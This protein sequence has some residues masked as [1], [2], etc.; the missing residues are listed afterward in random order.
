MSKLISNRIEKKEAMRQ[1][2]W[3][4]PQVYNVVQI[5]TKSWHEDLKCT[6]EIH[7]DSENVPQISLARPSVHL[8]ARPIINYIIWLFRI[9]MSWA[10]WHWK[11]AALPGSWQRPW[12]TVWVGAGADRRRSPE[13]EHRVG[14]ACWP[15]PGSPA[16]AARQSPAIPEY[17][18]NRAVKSGPGLLLGQSAYCSRTPGCC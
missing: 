10:A 6:L 14:R 5:Y 9:P 18:G 12:W 11:S 16:A 7:D 17:M 13:A 8:A 15:D 1:V 2:R 4:P 3:N